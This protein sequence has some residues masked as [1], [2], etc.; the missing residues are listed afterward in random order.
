MS[1]PLFIELYNRIENYRNN[2]LNNKTNHPSTDLNLYIIHLPDYNHLNS[3]ETE[4]ITNLVDNFKTTKYKVE[5]VIRER[6]LT[7]IE[8]KELER[9]GVKPTTSFERKLLVSW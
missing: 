5:L 8:L 1:D 7:A 9:A 4:V 2:R 6:I 3:L